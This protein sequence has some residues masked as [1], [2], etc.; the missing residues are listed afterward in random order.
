MSHRFLSSTYYESIQR[1]L[2]LLACW[3]GPEIDFEFGDELCVF[4]VFV[5]VELV[6]FC[7]DGRGWSEIVTEELEGRQVLIFYGVD[8]CLLSLQVVATAKEVIGEIAKCPEIFLAH[9]LDNCS[10]FVAFSVRKVE[11]QISEGPI[12][13]IPSTFRVFHSVAQKFELTF[14]LEID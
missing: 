13:F 6:V 11:L 9:L 3:V 1:K 7:F 12:V 8:L 10:H 2:F 4:N 5:F 14:V